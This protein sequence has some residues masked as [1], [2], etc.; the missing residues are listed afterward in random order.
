MRELFPNIT[1]EANEEVREQELKEW[2]NLKFFK[3]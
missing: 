1:G 2:A 3:H